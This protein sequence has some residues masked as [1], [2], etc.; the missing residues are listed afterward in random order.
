MKDLG[1]WRN[2]ELQ[3]YED[4][5]RYWRFSP[6][7]VDEFIG[8]INCRRAGREKL[9]CF[10][11]KKTSN[12]AKRGFAVTF[13]WTDKARIVIHFFIWKW[14]SLEQCVGRYKIDSGKWVRNDA[15]A[16]QAYDS[17]PFCSLISS[18]YGARGLTG[19]LFYVKEHF[20]P[21]SKKEQNHIDH[22]ALTGPTK[23]SCIVKRS[24]YQYINCLNQ[25]CIVYESWQWVS[26]YRWFLNS[27]AAVSC[28]VIRNDRIVNW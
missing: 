25:C 21:K 2:Q 3:V 10:P 26:R 27:Q 20:Q 19:W 4:Y 1:F 16:F 28:K 12:C 22:R 9:I 7:K 23:A 5:F 8:E 14:C 17:K 18:L 24:E 15:I 11:G 6:K 13:S